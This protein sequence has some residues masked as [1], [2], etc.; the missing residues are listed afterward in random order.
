MKTF[1]R[2]GSCWVVVAVLAACAGPGVGER[3]RAPTAASRDRDLA[4]IRVVELEVAPQGPW[5]ERYG[6]DL[7][8]ELSASERALADMLSRLPLRHAASLS[9]ATREIARTSPD[10][11]NVPPAL[12]DGLMAWAGLVHPPP[13][14]VTVEIPDDADGC[15]RAPGESCRAAMDSLVAQVRVTMAG[16]RDFHYGVGVARGSTGSTRMMVALLEKTVEL[17]PLAVSVAARDR[18]ALRGTLSSGLRNPTIDVID[19]RGE[20]TSQPASVSS[21]GSFAVDVSCRGRGMHQVEVLAEGVHG[22]EVAANFP[23]YCGVRP[24]SALRVTLEELDPSISADQLA[25]AIYH[26][27]EEERRLRGLPSLEWDD[28]AAAVAE[29]HS[30]DMARH[31]YVGHRS[32][33]TGDVKNRF[34]RARIRYTVLRENVARG[35]GPRGIHDSLMNSPGH[36]VNIVAADVTHVGIGVVIAEP[37]TNVPG[38]P[39]PLFVTQNFYRKPGAGAPSDD[40]L[41]PTMRARVDAVRESAR[42]PPAQWDPK[43]EKIALRVAQAFAQGRSPGRFDAEVFELGYQSVETVRVESPD[44]EALATIDVWKQQPLHGAIGIAPVGR[45]EDRRFLMVVL[46]AVPE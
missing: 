42:L 29:E 45:G 41:V 4:G 21:N 18:L 44:F 9:R 3:G 36:R 28:R 26:Y 43:L 5:A 25:R 46:L 20:W 8:H 22:P 12:V 1:G 31:E 39:R 34:E 13:R 6:V 17:E 37:A 40:Q 24:P 19:P 11:A 7:P 2:A 32:P 27:L 38:A 33:R 30:L 35:Y 10:R 23:V 16:S 14:L 15:D